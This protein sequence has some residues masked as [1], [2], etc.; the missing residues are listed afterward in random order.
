[1]LNVTAVTWEVQ[2]RARRLPKRT[3]REVRISP[4]CVAQIACV[5][6][7]LRYTFSDDFVVCGQGRLGVSWGTWST[8]SWHAAI[9]CEQVPTTFRRRTTAFPLSQI[10]SLS[11]CAACPTPSRTRRD[12]PKVTAA[13]GDLRNGARRLLKRAVREVRALPAGCRSCAAAV[14]RLRQPCA[15]P[16]P[17]AARRCQACMGATL[18]Y[19][20][21]P[22]R[23]DS[24]VVARVLTEDLRSARRSMWPA[25]AHLR[26]R[27]HACIAAAIS[28][29]CRS[30][31]RS[32][33]RKLQM[34]PLANHRTPRVLH[35]SPQALPC[36]ADKL[37]ARA[38]RVK[39]RA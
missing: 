29:R 12:A 32:S 21:R 10:A 3:V 39:H 28:G 33:M 4:E 15:R 36:F 11:G 37:R 5:R 20:Q 23:G 25:A 26:S 31:S 18:G 35:K 30:S 16:A 19:R 2:N 13:A 1:M 22:L 34:Y 7:P 27:D 24:D 14:P 38:R 8:L 6:A 17:W 9:G